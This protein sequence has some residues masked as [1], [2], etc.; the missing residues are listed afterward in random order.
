MLKVK[1]K[2]LII[3]DN[4]IFCESVKDLLTDQNTDVLTANT[5]KDGLQLCTENKIDIVILDQKLPD[6]QGVTLCPSILKQNEQ[7][8]IIFVTAYPSFANAIDAIKVGAHDYLSK[9]FE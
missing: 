6:T 8:K 3:D 9:P 1:R 2:I 5:G 7:T 4:D